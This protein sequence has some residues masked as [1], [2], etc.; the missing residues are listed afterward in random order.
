MIRVK[1][2]I[3]FIFLFL[4][5]MKVASQ[6]TQLGTGL[7]HPGR[8][9]IYDNSNQQLIVG[10][11]FDLSGGI[12]TNRIASW[13]GVQWSSFG[14]GAPY[15]APVY[16][17]TRYQNNL[18]AS[19]I[20]LNNPS[21]QNWFNKWNGISWDTI[22]PT[23]NGPIACFKEYNGDLYLGGVFQQTNNNNLNMIAK[24]DGTSFY[25]FP[26]P[27]S[28][29]SVNAIEFFQ[30][31]MYIGGNFYDSIEQVN[32]LEMWNGTSFVPFG[33]NGLA[34]GPDFVNALAVYNNELYIGGWFTL[35][36]GDPANY[37][38]K[39]DGNQLQEVGGGLNGPVS[40]MKSY[41]DGLY[42]CGTFSMAGN[43][44]VPGI[45]RW[46]GNQWISVCDTFLNFG[47]TDFIVDNG[48]LYL[49]GGFDFIGSLNVNY[50]AKLEGTLLV[51]DKQNENSFSVQTI[52]HENILEIKEIKTAESNFNIKL[53]DTQGR[54]LLNKSFQTIALPG[55]IELPYLAQG[56]YFASLE[57]KNGK[58]SKVVIR[59]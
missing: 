27:A 5:F 59:E 44:Q 46:E 36:N 24:Y 34:A 50:I 17:I 47:I 22:S 30:G 37:I 26:L 8:C 54:I 12:T 42:I 1:T 28:Y 33:T 19:S 51:D 2:S 15:G 48:D 4:N 14:T 20:F 35:S 23:I 32:D 31:N 10:G 7:N 11:N 58:I 9:L 38:M 13:N 39:W 29:N 45:V 49:T 52:M 43:L 21:Q 40:R 16:S 6:W 57:T 53:T 3:I 41:N 18:Y 56:L 25:S 55:R